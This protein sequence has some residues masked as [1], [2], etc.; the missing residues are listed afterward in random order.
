M[1]VADQVQ[2]YVGR[3]IVEGEEQTAKVGKS[4]TEIREDHGQNRREQRSH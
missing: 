4:R 2:R 1:G 3:L